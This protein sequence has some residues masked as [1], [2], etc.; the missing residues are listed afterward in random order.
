MC[1]SDLE[2]GARF[3][4]L[5]V[6]S[7]TSSTGSFYFS[8]EKESIRLYDLLYCASALGPDEDGWTPVIRIVQAGSA[9]AG[10]FPEEAPGE[11]LVLS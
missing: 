8:R 9:L 7:E 11:G 6:L 4:L 2:E 5:A 1:S 10:K 3:E